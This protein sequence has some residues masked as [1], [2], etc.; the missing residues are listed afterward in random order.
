MP[1]K[2]STE[3]KTNASTN[4]DASNPNL[5][6]ATIT[7][8]P[9]TT[10][11]AI[12]PS[13][14][15]NQTSERDLETVDF[16]GPS[17]AVRHLFSLPY[18]TDR[19]VSVALHALGNGTILLD[20]G[21]DVAFD[22]HR[23]GRRRRP[24]SWSVEQPQDVSGETKGQESRLAMQ[25]QGEKSLL[26]SLSLLLEEERE[27]EKSNRETAVIGD[28]GKAVVKKK[29][30]LIQDVSKPI[31]QRSGDMQSN[32]AKTC[33]DANEENAI[34][35]DPKLKR[36]VILSDSN[37]AE[38]NASIFSQTK[39]TFSNNGPK[40]MLA[41][42]L[43]S[44][45]HYLSHV[46]SPPTEPNQYLRWNF[47][48]MNMLIASDANIYTHGTTGE[49]DRASDNS[50]SIVVK[51]AD[52]P[53]LRAQMKCHQSMVKA[54]TFVTSHKSL[55][56]SSY[57]EALRKETSDDNAKEG[58][59]ANDLEN[60]KLQTCIIPS[61]NV[62]NE[63]ADYGF[64]ISPSPSINDLSAT[65]NPTISETVEVHSEPMK[66]PPT[67]SNH[68][69]YSSTP[70]CTVMDTY[71]D[72]IMANV[73]QLALILREHG[74]IS[75]IKL[76]Q[77]EDIPSLLMHPS[78]T[79]GSA[80][81]PE[82]APEPI[83]SPEIVEMNAAMLLRFLK[84]NC[85]KE[86]STYLL[87]RS[88]GEPN[89]QLFDISSIS[90]LRQRKWI[91]WLALCSYRFA[92]RLEQLQAN[93]LSPHDKAMRREYRNRQRSLLHNTLDLLQELADMD[94]GK[95][96]TIGAAVYEH[97]ADT[98]LW[99]DEADGDTGCRD[100]NKPAPLA[101][102]SQPY[103]KVT[104]DCLNKAHD[105]LTKAIHVLNPLLLKAKE[106]DSPIELEAIS[107]Q[108]YGMH[109][110]LVNV[111]LR[112]ADS[113][114]QSYFSS[115]LVQSLRTAGRMLSDATFLLAPLNLIGFDKSEDATYTESILLQ[116]SW[117]WEYCGHFARSFA[118][119]G[120]WRDRGHT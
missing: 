15:D 21:E 118:A 120:L 77:T 31:R 26:A 69:P 61:I 7:N 17:S 66:N 106:D 91:W 2:P 108:L 79:D 3:K 112:L 44:P 103:G 47:Q 8:P 104:V 93:A 115:N 4:S 71:L 46:V 25:R 95:H 58:S 82:I 11:P 18:S 40:D 81:Y 94:G 43:D 90:Q 32:A 111:C 27:L 113:H 107:M 16:L 28:D 37:T 29:V 23:P 87:H 52:A 89:L 64:S 48:G 100:P 62:G 119:D 54:G 101:S 39:A 24:R 30:N 72:N 85:T 5:Q 14:T 9:I 41:D 60:V 45:Q 73:P 117:L 83:F 86:N 63:F 68:V 36:K 88:A 19:T 38:T 10:V 33:S 55:P 59:V 12:L 13:E 22:S 78:T 51:V 109:H 6:L 114:L 49:N 1:S 84:T 56:P 116:C 70:C 50:N 102:L 105:H 57:A 65:S 96:E 20:S 75:N 99:N 110:K 74:F 67:S 42:K 97:L 80:S 53:E 76:M 34:T 92:C 35:V 98:Y